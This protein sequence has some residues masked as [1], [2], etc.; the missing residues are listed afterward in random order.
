MSDPSSNADRLRLALGAW[1]ERGLRALSDGWW[2]DDI[3]WHDM[4]DLPDQVTALGR[5]R[6]EDRIRELVAAVG[7]FHFEVRSLEEDG[8]MTVAELELVGQGVQSGAAFIGRI[9][10]IQRWREG[11]VYEVF[12]FIDRDALLAAVHELRAGADPVSR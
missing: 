2:T 9:H 8:D 12:T 6:A 7:H 1:N 3:V 11:R 10:Q 4:P 5:E